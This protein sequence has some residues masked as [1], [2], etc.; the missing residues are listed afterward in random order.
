M[1]SKTKIALV[2]ASILSM[3]ALTACQSTNPVSEKDHAKMMKDHHPK[4]KNLSPEQREALKQQRAERQQAFEQIKKACDGQAVGQ[5]LQFKVGDKTI[6]GTCTMV[7]KA[8]KKAMK[9]LNDSHR[10]MKGEDRPMR[11]DIR[12][13]MKNHE[14]LTDAKRAELTQKFDQRLAERQARQQAFAQACQGKTN[15]QSAQIKL[16]EKQIDG[17]CEVRFKPEMPSKAA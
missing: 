4:G 6:N 13:P 8:D 7:F 11:G 2:S 16:A 15:G 12:G 10:P 14:P 1:K 17:K 9:E 3:G 5:T